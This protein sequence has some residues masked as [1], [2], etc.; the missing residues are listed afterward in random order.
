LRHGGLATV[1]CITAL[2]QCQLGHRLAAPRD[3]EHLT[4]LQAVDQLRQAVLGVE[5]CH[6]GHGS[7]PLQWLEQGLT[8][9]VL[10][11]AS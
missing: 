3:G 2:W 9:A 4:R 10:D 8:L 1:S 5:Q 6:L 7:T 11:L